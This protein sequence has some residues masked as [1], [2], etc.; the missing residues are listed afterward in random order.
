M[1]IVPQGML[2]CVGLA[3][4]LGVLF[5]VG[6]RSKP[7][8]VQS[9]VTNRSMGNMPPASM[10]TLTRSSD[11]IILG[12]V[13]SIVRECRRPMETHGPIRGA[14]TCYRVRV[15]E[16]LKADG[17][18]ERPDTLDLVLPGGKA[19]GVKFVWVGIPRLGVGKRYMLFLASFDTPAFRRAGVVHGF[20]GTEWGIDAYISE[21]SLRHGEFSVMLLEDGKARMPYDADQ[22]NLQPWRFLGRDGTPFG[23]SEAELRGWVRTEVS[24]QR[25]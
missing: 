10:L 17:A 8:A 16:Y 6:H 4:T 21:Y 13:D 7:S 9:T 20:D 15:E 19:E 25:W 14:Q 22:P 3:V 5:N 1:Q 24:M 12:R 23:R 11:T 18:A 2:V